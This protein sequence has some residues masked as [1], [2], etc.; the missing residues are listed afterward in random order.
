MPNYSTRCEGCGVSLSI[1]LS[2]SD[3]DAVK[4]G[5]KTMECA[6]CQGKV[7]LDFNPGDVTFVMKDGESG[8]WASKAGKENKY[9]S[10]RRLVMAKREKDHV[11]PHALVPN[12]AGE[13]VENWKEAKDMA[14]STAYD[15]TRN[16]AAAQTA[17]STYDPL[18]SQEK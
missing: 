9:R 13:I 5:T 2:F 15:E 14:F 8:G 4:L 7:I 16:T 3:Y 11:A 6:T 10:K 1:R 18:I 17:A 12:F